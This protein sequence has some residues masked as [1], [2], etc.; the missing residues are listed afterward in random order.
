MTYEEYRSNLSRI[1]FIENNIKAYRSNPNA[2]GLWVI[3][4]GNGYIVI[5]QE[6]GI[7]RTRLNFTGYAD[8]LEYFAKMKYSSLNRGF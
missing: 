1:G 3:P 7:T 2:D 5:D 6:R 4:E 8:V